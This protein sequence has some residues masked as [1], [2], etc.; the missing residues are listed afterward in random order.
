M[1]KL[2][3]SAV[4][5]S[6]L[7]V[8]APTQSFAQDAFSL[9]EEVVVTARKREESLQ[10]VPV[11][12]S[13]LSSDML[14]DAGIRTAYDLFDMTPGINWEQAQDRQGSRPSVRGVQTNAQNPVRQKVTSFLDGMPLL[15]QQGGLQFVGVERIEVMRG[16]QSAAFG[17]ATFAGAI[18]YVSRDPGEEFSGDVRLA[19]SD[20]GR[21]ELQLEIGGPINDTFGYTVDVNLDEF[22]GPDE[23]ISTDGFEMGAQATTYVTGKL[24]FAPNDNFDGYVRFIHTD[25]DDSPPIEFF[26]NPAERAACVNTTLPGMGVGY[27]QGEFNCSVSVPAG[28]YPLDHTPESNFTPGTTP[29]Y[30]AQTYSVLD[31]ASRVERNRIQG[32]FNFNTDNGSTLELLTFYSED[33]LRRWYDSD[34][35]N[36]VPVVM[37]TMAQGVSSMANPNTIEETY[38]E[39]RW[40]SPGDGRLTW[41]V[42]GSI[43]DYSSLTNVHSQFAGVVLGLEDLANGGNPFIP[44][45]VLSD[46]S[47][48]TGIYANVTYD[49]SDR[50]TLSLEGRFQRDDVTNID[51]V[52][53]NSFSNVTD[54]FQPRIGLNHTINDQVSV[55]GQISSGTNAAG[56]NLPYV[57]QL[58]IDSLAAAAAAGAVTFD[59]TTFLTFDEEELTNFEVGL[60]ATVLD[61]RLQ[62]TAALYVMDW[63]KM[64]QPFTLDWNG[65][66]NDGS[67]DPQGRTFGNPFV[68]GRSFLNTGTGNLS[69]L[70]LE[71]NWAFTENFSVRAALTLS[72]LEYDQF[73]DPIGVTTLGLPATDTPAT[74]AA[75]S[76]VEVGGNRLNEQP[77]ETLALSP[78]YR[79]GNIGNTDWNWVGRVDIRWS[80]K[81]YVDVQNIMALPA[82]MQINGSLAFQNENWTIRLYGNNLNDEDTPRRIQFNNDGAF[83]VAGPGRRNFLIRPRLPK[84]IGLQLSYDF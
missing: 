34:S 22:R 76:C 77:E 33:D 79:S 55:Y 82:S 9:L 32:Q 5:A 23:W 36:T 61:N 73:C 28:G 1:K 8:G 59:E 40:L 21:N 2:V 3:F 65:A 25:I 48:N 71:G 26:L 83:G 57:E 52:S 60:K 6:L 75:T 50:T 37:G 54:S 13:V 46:T 10:D 81:E 20:L 45:L 51:N 49:I 67:F 84:E 24:T 4:G 19:T 68:M 74:G 38:L 62:F 29:F 12:I 53:G 27:L 41:L 15:G 7:S 56:V 35:S 72:S 42:G 70:E 47:I 44:N 64:I 69:G 58:R 11:S 30:V 18:N 16:P 63:D 66:W 17:R 80:G 39:A 43:Y 31:P 78:T 14:V